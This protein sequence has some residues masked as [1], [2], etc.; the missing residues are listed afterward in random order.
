ME[1]TTEQ[2]C[3]AMMNVAR[4]KTEHTLPLYLDEKERPVLFNTIDDAV[5]AAG[6]LKQWHPEINFEVFEFY[7]P[8]K[9]A[10]EII[11]YGS[12]MIGKESVKKI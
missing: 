6:G 5:G 4:I 12:W 2:Y 10:Y 3:I 7:R 8:C 11:Q 9:Y 1:K